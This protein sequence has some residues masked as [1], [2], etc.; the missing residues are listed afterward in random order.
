MVISSI[1]Q[2]VTSLKF[3]AKSEAEKFS[4]RC[5]SRRFLAR[6]RCVLYAISYM[7]KS[8]WT[9]KK[10]IWAIDHYKHDC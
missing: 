3:G 5:G 6:E 4:L 7:T 9:P 1:S 10:S 2:N 8:M